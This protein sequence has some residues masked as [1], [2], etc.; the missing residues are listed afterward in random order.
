MIISNL[1]AF[2]LIRG[3]WVKWVSGGLGM[4]WGPSRRCGDDG[5][6]RDN[7]WRPQTMETTWG[8]SGDDGDDGDDVGTTWGQQGR[9]GDHM[10]DARTMGT[11]WGQQNH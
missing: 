5:D 6:D 10:D 4:M 9:H 2:L 1:I 11:T 3:G 8:P 7:M